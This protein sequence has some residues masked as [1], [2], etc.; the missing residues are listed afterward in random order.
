MANRIKKSLSGRSSLFR[1]NKLIFSSN[2]KAQYLPY[3]EEIDVA[4]SRVLNSGRY[5]LG[6]EVRTLEE[7]ISRY[8]GVPF[9]VGVGSGTAAIHC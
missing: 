7:A 8:I 2:P 9:G 4:V 5:I 6:E 3:K 1:V